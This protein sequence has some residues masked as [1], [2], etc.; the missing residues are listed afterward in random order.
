MTIHLRN[1]SFSDPL[2]L[3]KDL[4]HSEAMKAKKAKGK[5]D[6]QDASGLEIPKAAHHTIE[7]RKAAHGCKCLFFFSM[8]LCFF[9]HD[10]CFPD[11]LVKRIPHRQATQRNEI[12][13]S[14]R[15]N[16]GAQLRRAQH[17]LT[18]R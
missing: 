13:V 15:S 10:P 8:P 9:P 11:K 17:L 6:L 12:F 5:S 3:P 7:K 1:L 4:S 18:E 2:L 16:T 14:V